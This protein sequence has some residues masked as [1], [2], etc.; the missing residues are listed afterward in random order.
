MLKKP[1][2]FICLCML[3]S[4]K[5]CQKSKLAAKTATKWAPCDNFTL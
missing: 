5:M 1:N 2:V 3:F 4:C